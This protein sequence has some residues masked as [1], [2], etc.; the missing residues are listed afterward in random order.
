MR[1]TLEIP[2]LTA[3]FLTDLKISLQTTAATVG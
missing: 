3:L 1:A 2:D